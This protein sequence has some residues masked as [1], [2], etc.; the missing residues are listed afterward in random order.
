MPP[1][2][3]ARGATLVHSRVLTLAFL[4]PAPGEDRMNDL[5]ARASQ[6]G[7]C[8]A[9]LVFEGGVGFSIYYEEPTRMRQR[10]FSNP[11]YEM[12]SLSV[13]HMEYSACAQ[14]CSQAVKE[15]YPFDSWGMYLATIHPGGC[16]DRPSSAVGKTFCSK[17]ITEALQF[18]G[19]PEVSALSPSAV[20]PSRLYAAVRDSERRVCHAVR[21]M[22]LSKSRGSAG[23]VAQV[24]MK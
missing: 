15:A 19:L 18:A 11:G 2:A 12:V 7:M 3:A 17:I 10:T 1:L 8:H 13:S 22:Q 16:S 20:T 6:H 9:E 24:T 5:T 23:V 21:P 14:F 4:R